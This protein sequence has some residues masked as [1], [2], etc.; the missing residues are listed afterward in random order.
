MEDKGGKYFSCRYEHIHFDKGNTNMNGSIALTFVRSRHGTNGEGSDFS[1]SARQ[2]KVIAA[3]RGKI[4]S[5][6]TLANPQKISDLVQALGESIDTNISIKDAL[7]FF[8]LSKKL[9]QTQSIVLDDSLKT[10]LPNNRKSLL[11]HP[12]A[13]DYGGAYV[14]IS[15]DDDF[16]MLQEYI[17]KVINE[18]INNEATSSARS[19]N[20]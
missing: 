15:E 2:E 1:R 3:V 12:S 20:K 6:E 16:S 11:V 8:K 9:E 10:G 5:F 13:G 7:E 19:V 18:E 4:L 14:L 17:N